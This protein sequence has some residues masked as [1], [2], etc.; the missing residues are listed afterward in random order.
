MWPGGGQRRLFRGREICLATWTYGR[1]C[2]LL[3]GNSTSQ[4]PE[5]NGGLVSCR[6]SLFSESGV[7]AFGEGSRAR[8]EK[9]EAQTAKGLLYCVLKKMNLILKRVGS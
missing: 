4:E 8:L 1:R 2:T 5:V 7:R 6:N 3:R 9:S